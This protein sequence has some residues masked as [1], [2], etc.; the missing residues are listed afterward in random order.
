MAVAFAALL[1][2]P[3]AAAA[4]NAAYLAQDAPETQLAFV[5]GCFS[6]P[7]PDGKGFIGQCA[8][9]PAQSGPRIALHPGAATVRLDRVAAEVVVQ[10]A[11]R[12]VPVTRG[13]DT[14]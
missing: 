3:S 5:S 10:V 1:A 12:A 6:G 8:D 13:D 4:G 11:G 9:G 14:H 2:L 7:T